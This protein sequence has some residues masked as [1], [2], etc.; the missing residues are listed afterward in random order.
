M[1]PSADVAG[2]SRIAAVEI[3]RA[4]RGKSGSTMLQTRPIENG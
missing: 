2:A 3:R 1:T 4:T